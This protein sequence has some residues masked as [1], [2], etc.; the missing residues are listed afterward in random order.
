MDPMRR[1]SASE[2]GR[3]FCEILSQA[4]EGEPITITRQGE[5]IAVLGLCAEGRK[6]S[7]SWGRLLTALEI[8]VSLGGE[9]FNRDALYDR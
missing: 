5:P 4:K 3:R 8:G 7:G 9:H 6:S 2:A 1:I